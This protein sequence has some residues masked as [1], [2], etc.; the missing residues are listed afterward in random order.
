MRGKKFREASAHAS[1]VVSANV[2]SVRRPPRLAF[3][4]IAAFLDRSD[5]PP[6]RSGGRFGATPVRH[7][8]NFAA[9]VVE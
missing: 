4:A 2:F 3:V 6:A 9:I 1:G 8:M 5:A 7:F